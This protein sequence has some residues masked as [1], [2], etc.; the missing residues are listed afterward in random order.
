WRNFLKSRLYSVVNLTGLALGMAVS[1]LLG[2]WIWD[3]LS[4][5]NYHEHHSRI[6]KVMT[7][8]TFNGR[9]STEPVVSIPMVQELRTSYGANFKKITLTSWP[10]EHLV[11]V[12]T[13]KFFQTGL[14]VQP[15]FTEMF[16]L[17]M[18][19]GKATLDAPETVLISASL[20]KVLFDNEDPIGKIIRTDDKLNVSVVGVYEDWPHNTTFHDVKMLLPWDNYYLVDDWVKTAETQWDN[21]AFQ[22]FVQLGDAV[23]REKVDAKIKNIPLGHLPEGKEELFL[24]MMDDWH[25]YGEFDNGKMSGG[26]IQYVK[27]LAIIGVFVLLLACINF[28]NLST[29]RSEMRAKEVGIRKTMGSLK[30]QLIAQFLWETAFIVFFSLL[31]SLLAVQ[32]ALPFF[33][34]MADKHIFIPWANG[35]FWMGLLLFLLITSFLAGS[36]PAFFL[37]RFEAIKA[38]KGLVHVGHSGFT[39]RKML[40]VVQFTA[41]VTL[42]IATIVVYS[43][44][45]YAKNRVVGYDKEGLINI[46]I[47]NPA[48][49]SHYNAI[50]NDL[51][52]TGVVA[53]ASAASNASTERGTTN[54]NF[55]WTGKDV[56]SNVIFRTIAVT[57]DYGKTIDW[58]IKQGR[59]FSRN[60]P[61]DTGAFI[62]NEAAVKLLGFKDP[63]GQTILWNQKPRPILGVVKDMIMESP[64]EPVKPTIFFLNYSDS[65]ISVLSVRIKQ[66]A[67]LQGALD[68]IAA[69]FQK[70]DP[71]TPFVFKFND[72]EYARK[73]FNEER[74]GNLITFFSVFAIIISYI[75]LMG[76]A[77][78]IAERRTK[79]IG[80]R[81]VM[82]ASVGALWQLMSKEFVVLVLISCVISTPIAWYLLSRWLQQFAFR[83]EISWWIFI[84][85][86]VGTILTT[87]LTVSYKIIKTASINPIKSLRAD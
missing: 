9:V 58:K 72:E 51:L 18:I 23:D 43:Q 65:W 8:Q 63:V 5:N 68:E 61:T 75:G 4:F 28:V 52:Q 35:Y 66:G 46:E 67:P 34:N 11:N 30:G 48:M 41:S 55:Q 85:V 70:Y 79:E 59:D 69:V 22:A 73:F 7:N 87:L 57:H 24:H 21:Q 1:L 42:I 81:K 33:N 78:F 47:T 80:V 26:Y 82:G 13:R 56:T 64:Y 12:G 32:L 3:E 14:W 60:F 10:A 6:A 31:I 83:V 27:M 29:A 54:T 74:M 2:L 49:Y 50:R 53:E 17:K 15:D 25:L 38:L 86:A 37:S 36:Y 40:V 16:S 39:L 76:L 62:V 84:V 71:N 45:R 44:V 77:S 19:R 20:A